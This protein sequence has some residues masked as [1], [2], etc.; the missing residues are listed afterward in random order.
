MKILKYEILGEPKPKQSSRM[1][2]VNGK[3]RSFKSK[4]VKEAENNIINQI[5]PQHVNQYDGVITDPIRVR[6]L[7]YVF[8]PLKSFSMKKMILLNEG[9]ELY[10][11]TKP[12][13]TD[14]L[15]KPLFDAMESIVYAND[16][17]IVEITESKKVYGIKPRIEIE[18]E[19]VD[20]HLVA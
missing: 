3:V 18:L 16:S 10:K 4:T 12:D 5:I 15:N 17:Q 14:N 13:L 20:K 9:I 8:A 11:R 19:I 6:R 1:A 7:K 2:V